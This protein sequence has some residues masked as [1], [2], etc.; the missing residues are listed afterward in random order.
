MFVVLSVSVGSSCGNSADD[1]WLLTALV[2][3]E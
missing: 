2:S 3:M 1:V